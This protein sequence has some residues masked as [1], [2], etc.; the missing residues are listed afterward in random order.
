M[1]EGLLGGDYQRYISSQLRISE[2]MPCVTVTL[3]T[4]ASRDVS[5]SSTLLS[6]NTTTFSLPSV[7]DF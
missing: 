1:G 2:N 4:K 5:P 7:I 3:C 6:L